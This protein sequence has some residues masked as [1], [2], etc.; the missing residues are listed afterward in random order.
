MK[1]IWKDIEGYE[2]YYQ[3]SNRGRVRSLDRVVNKNNG[4]TEFNKGIIRRLT[5][6]KRGY[7][8]VYLLK[9]GKGKAGKVHR[10]VLEAFTPNPFNKCCVNHI[11]GNKRNNDIENLE[12][13]T[14]KENMA[15]ASKMG[16]LSYKNSK[17]VRMLDINGH[18]IKKFKSIKDACLEVTN[19]RLSKCDIG[20]ACNKKPHYNTIYGYKWEYVTKEEIK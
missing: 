8:I 9:N 3:V 17:S 19:G 15:H 5:P 13:V 6:D 11:D 18:F 4:R 20:R 12:W 16:L 10:L 1:E 14:H 2:K 7:L